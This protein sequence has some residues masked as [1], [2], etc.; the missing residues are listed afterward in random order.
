MRSDGDVLG[1]GV[2]LIRN[3]LAES[4]LC[5]W[6]CCRTNMGAASRSED[7]SPRIA[8]ATSVVMGFTILCI[9]IGDFRL[10]EPDC[11]SSKSDK[12]LDSF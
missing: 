6:L 5:S 12:I 4:T 11:R 9:D 3:V 7:S 1:E 10:G 8:F 2:K